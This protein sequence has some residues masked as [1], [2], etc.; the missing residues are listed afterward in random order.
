[1]M[2]ITNYTADIT[3]ISALDEMHRRNNEFFKS[4]DMRREIN[5]RLEQVCTDKKFKKLDESIV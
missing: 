4:D 5:N 1:M 3:N 2:M